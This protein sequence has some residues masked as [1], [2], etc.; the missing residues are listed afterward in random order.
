M[1]LSEDLPSLVELVKELGIQEEVLSQPIRYMQD[2]ILTHLLSDKSFT[3]SVL[4]ELF[5]SLMDTDEN[6]IEKINSIH[7]V[8]LKVCRIHHQYQIDLAIQQLFKDGEASI[9]E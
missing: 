8:S 4:L 3:E 7:G 6:D 1:R 5:K 2:S 9:K